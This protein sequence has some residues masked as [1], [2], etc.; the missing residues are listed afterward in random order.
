MTAG[1][2]SRWASVAGIV[3]GL[4]VLGGVGLLVPPDVRW[5]VI[6]SALMALA[7]VSVALFAR[8]RERAE[9]RWLRL[10]LDSSEHL[11]A[12]ADVR[13]ALRHMA[14]RIVPE[15]ADVCIVDF[16]RADGTF[17]RVAAVRDDNGSIAA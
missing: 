10:L 5:P 9:R 17:D 15:L 16:L 8:R 13:L 1:A 4:A 11:M 3:L 6:A 14:R 2:D 7:V 12:P